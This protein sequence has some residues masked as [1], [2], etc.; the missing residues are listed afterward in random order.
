MWFFFS[1]K[2]C[3]CL[4]LKSKWLK[5]VFVVYFFA[6][7]SSDCITVFVHFYI[8]SSIFMRC[9]ILLLW[10]R[11]WQVFY[12]FLMCK[13]YLI[14]EVSFF[15]SWYRK[16]L[17]QLKATLLNSIIDILFIFA[18]LVLSWSRTSLLGVNHSD[19]DQLHLP[20]VTYV[21]DFNCKS[22]AE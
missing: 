20:D 4:L 1:S 16:R 22:L 10:R 7:Y 17:Q 19:C 13:P 18:V 3:G 2:I 9:F 5:I 21:G 15:K 14:S 12:L 8:Q 6:L 11:F